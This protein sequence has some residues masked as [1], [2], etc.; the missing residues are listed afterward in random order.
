MSLSP[1]VDRG[2][3]T[4][5]KRVAQAAF[6][7][8]TF[9]MRLRDILGPLFT[10]EAFAG[11]FSGRG[12]PAESP[13]TLALVSVLQFVEGLTDTQATDAVRSRVDWK[14]LLG[15]E[16]T[17]QGLDSSVLTEFRGRLVESGSAEALASV[18]H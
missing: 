14:Y 4:E 9:C 16:L 5:T 13:G 7:K 3:P 1:R 17:D 10:D 11:L 8:M 18:F 2:I 12:R 6:P 15:L